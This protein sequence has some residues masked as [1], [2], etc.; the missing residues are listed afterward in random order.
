MDRVAVIDKMGYKWDEN[1]KEK[2]SFAR[3]KVDVGTD[4]ERF[5]ERF[6]L[7]KDNLQFMEYLTFDEELYA[8]IKAEIITQGELFHSGGVAY[9]DWNEIHV[10]F[11]EVEITNKTCTLMVYIIYLNNY[12]PIFPD[13]HDH[14]HGQ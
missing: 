8:G 4:C 2:A 14:D 13:F 7:W 10:Q 5:E 11:E 9:Y 6:W 12:N 3:S 1:D